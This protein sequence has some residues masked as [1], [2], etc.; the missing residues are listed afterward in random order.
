M[1]LRLARLALEEA[2]RTDAEQAARR[3]REEFERRWPAIVRAGGAAGPSAPRARAACPL[4][5]GPAQVEPRPR[6][7]PLAPARREGGGRRRAA[8]TAPVRRPAA[9]SRPRRLL[10]ADRPA[11]KPKRARAPKPQPAPLPEFWT[12]GLVL[13]FRMWDLRGRLLGAWKPWDRPEYE[14]RCLSRRTGPDAGEVPHT[15]GRCGHPPCGLYC[16][17]EPEQLLAAFGLPTG[18]A[19]WVLGLVSLSG[20]VVEHESGYRAQKARVLAAA[21]VGRGRIVRIEGDAR[22][23]ALFADPEATIAGLLSADPAVVEEVGD[24][25]RMVE[26][27]DLLPVAWRATSTSRR[28][29]APE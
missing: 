27:V 18:T 2:I 10:R 28:A 22:L 25:V 29:A 9:P 5:A 3:R 7:P 26:A 16:F 11:A 14:A 6:A 23:Q 1:R 4:P 12:P 17:K 13:G 8:P 21:V 24:P 15:D 20:K 19:R